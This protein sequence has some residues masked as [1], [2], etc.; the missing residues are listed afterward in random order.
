MESSTPLCADGRF[1]LRFAATGPG[2]HDYVFPC[3]EHGLVDLDTL[4][5]RDRTEYFFA[6]ADRAGRGAAGGGDP[7]I[8]LVPRGCCLA[9][10]GSR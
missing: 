6:R 7:G 5:E 2:G 8:Y 3:D 10:P 9:R 4:P 1:E